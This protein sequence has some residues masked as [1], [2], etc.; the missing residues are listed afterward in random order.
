M[1]T[2]SFVS[3]SYNI[4]KLH[5]RPHFTWKVIISNFQVASSPLF[6]VY[7][8]FKKMHNGDL[9]IILMSWYCLCNNKHIC[10]LHQNFKEKCDGSKFI[11]KLYIKLTFYSITFQLSDMFFKHARN[12]DKYTLH[13][14]SIPLYMLWLLL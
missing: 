4:Q 5:C 10:V 9:I 11:F 1:Y 3:S 12:L 2:I 13:K 14:H 7:L 6:N 8:H